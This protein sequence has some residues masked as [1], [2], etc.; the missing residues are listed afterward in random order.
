[1]WLQALRQH[2]QQHS[3]QGETQLQAQTQAQVDAQSKTET[4]ARAHTLE[5]A[6]ARPFR[7]KLVCWLFCP[8]LSCLFPVVLGFRRL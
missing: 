1:M 4:P 7:L 2:S 6:A 5:T 8:L 3:A